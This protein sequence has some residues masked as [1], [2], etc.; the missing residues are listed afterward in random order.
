MVDLGWPIAVTGGD[1]GASALNHAVFRGDPT[2]ARF[3]LDHGAA[4]TER[5]GHGGNVGGTL[6]WASRNRPSS[7]G[8]WVG[9]A[10][11]LVAHGMP[12]DLPE[13]YGD[14][15]TDYFERARDERR[16]RASR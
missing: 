3:L 6:A 8:D 4:W 9:C 16:A 2:L 5:H 1:W 15:V 13:T 10:E 12:L 14:D 7:H 11:V